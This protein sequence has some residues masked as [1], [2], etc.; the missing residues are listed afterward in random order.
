M[1][2]YKSKQAARKLAEVSANKGYVIIYTDGS[3]INKKIGAAAVSL[4]IGL[5]YRIYLGLSN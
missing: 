4:D 5:P 2:I 3:G 1:T